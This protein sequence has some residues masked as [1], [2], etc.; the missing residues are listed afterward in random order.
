MNSLQR[1]RTSWP[2]SGNILTPRP[3]PNILHDVLNSE[4]SPALECLIVEGMHPLPEF[5]EARMRLAISTRI[6]E[7][8]TIDSLLV[9]AN[10]RNER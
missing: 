9:A 5:Y 4:F 2:K 3:G 7:S 8:P 6:C 10:R 1:R